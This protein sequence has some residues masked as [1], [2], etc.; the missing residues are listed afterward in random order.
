MLHQLQ[1]SAQPLSVQPLSGA[2]ELKA[3]DVNMV[4]CICVRVTV[5][6]AIQDTV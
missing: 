2:T 5:R 6:A 1:C 3:V 4:I